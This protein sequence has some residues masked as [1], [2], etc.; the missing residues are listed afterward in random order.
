MIWT[1]KLSSV[2]YCKLIFVVCFEKRVSQPA[3]HPTS[4][5]LAVIH[6][7]AGSSSAIWSMHVREFRCWCF[8]L[9]AE[10][11]SILSQRNRKIDCVLFVGLHWRAAHHHGHG[12]CDCEFTHIVHSNDSY[13]CS[14][15][16]NNHSFS[17]NSIMIH[18]DSEAHLEQRNLSANLNSNETNEAIVIWKCNWERILLFVGAAYGF[19][20]C[21]YGSKW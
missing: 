8:K 15:F 13:F 2:H 7:P 9:D 17:K 12:I 6:V 5:H 1:N 3:G 10:S 21:A 18:E 20:H 4:N 16:L 11:H 19:S 14:S